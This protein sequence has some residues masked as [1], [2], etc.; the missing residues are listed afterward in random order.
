[1]DCG[2]RIRRGRAG[3]ESVSYC[4]WSSDDFACDVYV[5]EDCG[6]GW[7]T[8]VARFKTVGDVPKTPPMHSDGIDSKAWIA[9][10][11]A[12]HNAQMAFLETAERA[13]IGLPFDGETFNDP[14]PGQCADRL[15]L[16]R[17]LGYCV[18]QYAIDEL[19]EEQGNNE[20]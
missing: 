7:T 10:Y 18:P 9:E 17:G 19:R 6:G 16:L 20:P 11:M 12:A 5:Y 1:M 8:H 4:R 14:T 13:P 15:E 2:G 3:G